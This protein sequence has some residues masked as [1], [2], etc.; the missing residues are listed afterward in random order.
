[1]YNH[2]DTFY[3]GCEDN[4]EKA[5]FNDNILRI[6]H[7]MSMAHRFI[8]EILSTHFFKAQVIAEDGV[9]NKPYKLAIYSSK[10]TLDKKVKET[11]IYTKKENF[12]FF[13]KNMH[14]PKN[15]MIVSF[16]EVDEMRDNIPPY[17]G[18]RHTWPLN[19]DWQWIGDG[20]YVTLQDLEPKTLE[21]TK[22]EFMAHSNYSIMKNVD[23]IC[24]YPIKRI[25]YT[26]TEDEIFTLLKHAK[27][28]LSYP[29]AT[30]YSAQLI[31][32]PTIGLYMDLEF[33]DVTYKNEEGERI[34]TTI[35]LNMAERVNS[36]IA[37]GGY[38]GYDFDNERA[39]IKHQTYLRHVTN[40]ELECYLKGYADY[41]Y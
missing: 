8:I 25:N 6:H 27:F 39:S 9:T 11:N 20:D 5:L 40:S 34:N 19:K 38:F 37:T 10:G 1:M 31:N 28:H 36:F 7:R 35:P 33:R 4:G 21:H 22:Q 18:F 17:E 30:Y 13:V 16:Y 24:I 32:C 29:G 15:G 26:M 14:P 3:I 23:D 41:K 2:I 12:Y